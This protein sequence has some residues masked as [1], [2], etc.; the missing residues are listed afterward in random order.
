M[1][2]VNGLST[3]RFGVAI[4]TELARARVQEFLEQMQRSK[5]AYDQRRGQ[6]GYV[7]DPAYIEAERQINEQIALVERIAHEFDP[8]LAT[9]VRTK[10]RV[11]WAHYEKI[12]A[13]EEILGRIRLAEEEEAIFGV[14]GPQLSAALMHPWVWGVAAS[15]W[16][17][18]YRREAVQAAATSVFDS[19]LPAKLGVPSGTQPKDL[20]NAFSTD[21]PKAGQPRLRLPGHTQGDKN[22][23]S[24]HDGAKFLGFAC[25]AG[26]RNIATHSVAQP[27]EQV[28][29]EALAAMSLFA[30]WADEATIDTI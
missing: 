20:A 18:G 25:A 12:K 6:Y 5:G 13:C 29:L 26:V 11:G 28:A 14:K 1:I 8:T 17:D 10:S 22:W 16:D 3:E 21:P 2:A 27:D 7:D 24:A 19:H 9:R 30:R 15:L 23:T 4:D